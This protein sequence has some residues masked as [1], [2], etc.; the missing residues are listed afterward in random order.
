MDLTKFNDLTALS[1]SP[2]CC[3]CYLLKGPEGNLLID[4]GDGSIYF[5]F[6]PTIT[7]LTHNHYDHTQGIEKKWDNVFLH[8]HDFEKT[9]FSYVPEKLKEIEFEN[10]KWGKWDLDIIHTPGHTKGS[11]CLYDKNRK[12]LFSG[13]TLFKNGKSRTD[14]GGNEELLK[15]S[16]KKLEKLEIEHLFPGHNY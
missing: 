12:V 16:L 13:D 7:I 14:L 9:E 11:I 10:I 8:K 3:V 6:K 1:G 5:G 4:T 2:Y 15:N